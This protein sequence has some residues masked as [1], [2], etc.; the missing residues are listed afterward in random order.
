MA[1]VQV[2]CITKPHPQ[3]PHEHITELGNPRVGWKW[4][5]E[6]VIASIN[7]KTN[8]FFV[9]DPITGKRA[10]IGVV[11]HPYFAVTGSG[12]TFTLRDVPPGTY[13][14]EAWHEK[15]GTQ[16]QTPP[17]SSPSTPAWT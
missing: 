2:T 6:Q 16:T 12:G 9:V 7:A 11:N 10:Y 3:S 5:R 14:I 15:S 17:S 1:D 13:T 8:T 4:P